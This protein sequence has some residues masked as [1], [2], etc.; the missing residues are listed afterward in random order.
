MSMDWMDIHL[1][2]VCEFLYLKPWE[3]NRLAFYTTDSNMLG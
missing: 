3:D 1:Q 2:V